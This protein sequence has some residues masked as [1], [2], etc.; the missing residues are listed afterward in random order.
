MRIAI[1]HNLPSGGGKRALHEMTRRLAKR[2]RIDLYTLSTADQEFCDLRPYSAR[3]VVVRFEPVPLAQSPFGRLNQ[4]IR[5]VDLLRLR[6]LQ[7]R[8][9]S[10]IDAEGYDVVFVHHCQYGQSPALLSYLRTASVYYCQEPPRQLHEPPIPRPYNT[11]SRPQRLLNLLD[12]L[13]GLYRTTLGR[14][15]RGN[16]SAADLVL[17]NSAY[18]RESLYRV[19]GIFARV[20]YLGVDAEQFRR[21]GL[22]QEDFVLSVGYLNAR[23]GF[24]FLARALAAIDSGCRP[25]LII[26]SNGIDERERG[27]LY[28][29]TRQ[30]N[31]DVGFR[32]Q[33]SDEDLVTLYNQAKLTLYAPIMEPFGFVPLESMGC[34]TPVVGVR[35]GGVRET[36]LH[37]KT[38]LLT[39]RDPKVFG[40]AVKG[41]LNDSTRRRRM[42]Q[43]G[44]AYV[45]REWH[46]D[47][48]VQRLE[49]YLAQAQDQRR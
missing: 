49:R 40:A 44:K 12:P 5:A 16:V 8:I 7:R 30:L 33:V 38:G 19:Y 21:L 41:L 29:L 1:Y 45:E 42:G 37:D 14:L 17:V 46:W 28:E 32:L 31:V 9:A 10:G 34:G 11:F 6:R 36:I 25:R 22:T 24:D 27:Y 23:K 13:P 47:R 26:V 43:E 15:D 48:S 2:H 35:E 4:G 20:C 3:H 39:D 18:S